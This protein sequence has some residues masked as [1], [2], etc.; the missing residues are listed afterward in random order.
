MLEE[1][2]EDLKKRMSDYTDSRQP[3][4]D[5]VRIAWL[6]G[7]IDRITAV[8]EVRISWLLEEINRLTAEN[9]AYSIK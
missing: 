9:A 5:E 7:E 4:G 8:D 6:L 2:R 3:T 1:I